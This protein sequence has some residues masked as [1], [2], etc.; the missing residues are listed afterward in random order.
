MNK[1]QRKI[2]K[3]IALCLTLA[4]ML[5][6]SLTAFAAGGIMPDTK[7]SITV[8]GVNAGTTVSAYQVITVNVS[9]D[10]QPKNPM[11]T[12]NTAVAEWLKGND[13]YKG[14]VDETDNSVED[15]FKKAEEDPEFSNFKSFW[16]DLAA[17]IKSG[18]IA[19]NVTKEETANSA[20]V[21]F[22][23]MPMGQ[24]L[25]TANGGVKIYQPTTAELL[26]THNGSE[27][28]LSDAAVNMKGEE[29]TITKSLVYDE[30]KTVAIG[31][32]VEY[33]LDVTVP[34]YPENAT[35]T[36]FIVEDTSA[37]GLTCKDDVRVFAGSQEI[38]A[39]KD[40]YTLDTSEE[41]KDFV[42]T[43]AD[44]FTA[45]HAGEVIQITYSATVNSTAYAA[46]TLK[47][48]AT[49]TYDT[50]AYAES[51]T[52]VNSTAQ[53]YTYGID[54]TKVNKAGEALD[55]AE[56]Q[57]KSGNELVKFSGNNGV[58]V[59]DA[60]GKETVGV[61]ADESTRGN[62]QLKG[63]DVGT[64]VL[65]ET[66]APNGYVLPN[67]KIIIVIKDAK[68]LDGTI[69]G[70]DVTADGTIKLY[71][72]TA[73]IVDDNTVSFKVENTSAEDAGFQL[74]TTGGMGTLLF[75]VAGILLMGGAVILVIS[76]KKKSHQA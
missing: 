54:L 50:D 45:A 40:T 75:T 74:P 65:T 48:T 10:G 44:A 61:S 68:D 21:A 34:S 3:L 66:K 26:P 23:D 19:L 46:D 28:M 16:H 41:A 31:D 52:Q 12:W 29:P 42:V 69:D 9:E 4:M 36:T 53:V 8:S 2:S 55:G 73:E 13:N 51:N 1:K 59:K 14:Y 56:F 35:A 71:E 62:L 5:S 49:L 70:T 15:T 32:T 72:N 63:L 11:Y 25:L 7:G 58:Y 67:G 27:W 60:D 43:F 18:K 39:G 30:D 38:A 57:L 47:N 6:M 33:Q 37:A 64:Y 24:Y 20:T 76:V 17:A 22:T